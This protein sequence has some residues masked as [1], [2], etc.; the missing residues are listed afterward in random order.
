M[1]ENWCAL[2]PCSAGE[3]WALPQSCLAEVI[4]SENIAERPPALLTWRGRR[5]PLLD[6][7]TQEDAPWSAGATPALAAV[8]LGLEGYGCDY[9]AV[10]LRGRGLS[11][12]DLA[13]QPLRDTPEERRAHSYSA[14]ELG[15]VIYQ[16]PDLTY[17][18]QQL[19]EQQ[20]PAPDIDGEP[21]Q[22]T[23]EI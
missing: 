10:A 15:G 14:F 5:I 13:P 21:S 22:P 16:V 1:Q 8:I 7:G 11:I 2:L 17:W 6:L 23:A 4:A 18:Q 19:S 20:A 3:H 9:W 12:K